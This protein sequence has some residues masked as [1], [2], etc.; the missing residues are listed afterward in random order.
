MSLRKMYLKFC[1]LG[2]KYILSFTIVN[3]KVEE[4]FTLFQCLPTLNVLDM[5][6][7]HAIVNNQPHKLHLCEKLKQKYT[8]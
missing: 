1:I 7:L 3:M 2:T 4:M 5:M 6:Y 8:K